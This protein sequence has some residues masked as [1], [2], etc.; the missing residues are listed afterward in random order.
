M[1]P[2]TR[3]GCRVTG[4]FPLEET[5]RALDDLV[6]KGKVRHIG[7]CNLSAGDLKCGQGITARTHRTRVVSN[8]VD[9]VVG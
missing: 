1:R 7:V 8:Q 5:L 9:R 3:T 2:A 4:C 6:T